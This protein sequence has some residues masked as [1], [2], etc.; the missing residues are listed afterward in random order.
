[1]DNKYPGYSWE[2]LAVT[3]ED[4]YELNMFHIWKEGEMIEERGPIMF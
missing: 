3:T 2:A 1:M 4:D